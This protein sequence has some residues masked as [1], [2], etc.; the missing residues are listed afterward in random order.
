[1]AIFFPPYVVIKQ[2]V[3]QSSLWICD[4]THLFHYL[5]WNQKNAL[6]SKQK[7]VFAFSDEARNI[8]AKHQLRERKT[9]AKFLYIYFLLP[10]GLIPDRCLDG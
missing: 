7:F 5:S 2:P 1:M 10:T 6:M 9:S 8:L 4:L 3:T